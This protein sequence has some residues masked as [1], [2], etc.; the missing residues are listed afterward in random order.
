MISQRLMCCLWRTMIQPISSGQ[1]QALLLRPKPT[2]QRVIGPTG[3]EIKHIKPYIIAA[4]QTPLMYL[5][6]RYLT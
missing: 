3:D 2:V 6:H 1:F 5:S 4:N